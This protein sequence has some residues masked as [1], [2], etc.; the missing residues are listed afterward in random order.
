VAQTATQQV[1]YPEL[2]FAS[3][4]IADLHRV[5]ADLRQ[6]RPVAPVTFHGER[7]WMLTRYDDVEAAFRDEETLPAEAAYRLHSEPVMGRTLQC[8]T[9]AEHA[10]NRALVFPAFRA[11]LMPDYVTP[12]LEPVANA[13][14]DAFIERGEADLVGEFTRQYPYTVITRLLGIPPRD[15]GDFQR[16]AQA[17]LSFPWDPEAALAASAEFTTYLTPVVAERRRQPG[18]DLLSTLATAEIDGSQLSDEEIFSFIRVL[19]PAGADT[20][21]RGLGSLLLAL[22]T[23]EGALDRVRSDPSARRLAIEEALRW[24]A[25]VALMPRFAPVETAQFGETIPAGSPVIFAVAA[26]NRDPAVFD[27]PDAYV[28]DRDP[29]GLLTF[30][31]GMHFCVGAHLARAE[32]AAG[33]D[34][35]LARLGH[36][37]LTDPSRVRVS[38]TVL[39]GPAAL[40]V[41]FDPVAPA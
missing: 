41:C 7:S 34:V 36:L 2:D 40:P 12:V 38:G 6:R 31:Y 25:P 16:W 11:R 1:E 21:Y 13:L 14:I 4:D 37:T 32:M 28:L 8:M 15:D 23:H 18:P 26:A 24:E 30:G 20:T 35:V 5:L 39:R 9:G 29:K 17:L 10:R 33:L 3:E 22:M 27:D 19:F